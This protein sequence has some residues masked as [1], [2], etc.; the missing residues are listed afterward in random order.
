MAKRASGAIIFD[1]DGTI[2]DS[3]L[4]ML[5][6]VYELVH[7]EPLPQEDVS[8]LRGM[9]AFGLLREL[10]VPLWRIPFLVGR[11]RR[12]MK[13]RMDEVGIIPGLAEALKVLQKKYT[14]FVLSANSAS[15]VRIFLRRF[16]IEGCFSDVYGGVGPFRKASALGRLTH[17][18]GLHAVDTWYVGD[19]AWD[20]R[21]ARRVG[22]KS[23]A[24]TW[25][26]NNI[27]QLNLSHP[28]A[29]VF[30]VDELVRC[31]ENN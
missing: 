24:V 18:K 17:Q 6:V 15:N 13:V 11:V 2:A 28:D 19:E 7:H 16:G 21:A 4:I 30:D 22:M 10:R 3:F 29:L 9:T 8:R 23:V 14:L 5:D 27:R 26:Y 1:F 12:H 25:G 20:V 31:F